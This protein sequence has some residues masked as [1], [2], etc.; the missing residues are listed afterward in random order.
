MLHRNL[1]TARRGVTV[2]RRSS[3]AASDDLG[4]APLQPHPARRGVTVRSGAASLQHPTTTGDSPLQPHGSTARRD[5]AP[6]KLHH[7][8]KTAPTMISAPAQH[9]TTW[10]CSIIELASHHSFIAALGYWKA[11]RVAIG[12]RLPHGAQLVRVS[13]TT[14]PFCSILRMAARC[15]GLQHHKHIAPGR[16]QG[17]G[18]RSL[19]MVATVRWQQPGYLTAPA[20]AATPRSTIVPPSAACSTNCRGSV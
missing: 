9:H 12:R 1:I 16:G 13:S 2:L 11:G 6:V 4:D 14:I 18:I 20:S 3:I 7:S 15:A 8:T 19:D 17:V 10:R 5:G